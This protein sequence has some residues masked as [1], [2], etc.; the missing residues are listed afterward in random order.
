MTDLPDSYVD[1]MPCDTD[2]LVELG[3]VAWAAARL[4][5]GV[6]D[7]INRHHGTSS[8]AP[9]ECTLGQAI[10]ELEGLANTAKRPDQAAWVR[11]FGRPASRRRNTVIH[12]I[13]FTAEDGRQAIGTVDHSHPG[14]F[15][16]PELRAVTLA[17]IHASMMLSE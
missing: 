14:R 12:A 7:A 2:L 3:R 10:G 1:T 9:F 4:H 15:L 16:V 11:Q 5:A 6:R 17:L 8:D 13:T